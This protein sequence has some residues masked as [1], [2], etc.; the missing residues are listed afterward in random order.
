MDILAKVAG[1][2]LILSSIVGLINFIRLIIFMVHINR[3]EE[4]VLLSISTVSAISALGLFVAYMI[5]YWGMQLLDVPDSIVEQVG[6]IGLYVSM[7]LVCVYMVGFSW[8]GIIAGRWEW[9]F[10][11]RSQSIGSYLCSA[12]GIWGIATIVY[13]FI[14]GFS[15]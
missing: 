1:G 14:N 10:G 8:G 7:F 12:I 2:V 15:H 11:N 13:G 6:V 9:A 5:S 3:R 4:S